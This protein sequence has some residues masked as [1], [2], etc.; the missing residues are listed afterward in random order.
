MHKPK[1]IEINIPHPCTQSWD[2][3]VPDGQGRYCAHC[4]KTVVDFTGWSDA[5]LFDF[6]AK[7]KGRSCGRFLPSQLNRQINIPHQPDSQ[8]YRLTIALGLTLLFTQTPDLLAQSKPPIASNQIA[9]QQTTVGLLGSVYDAR[10]EPTIN[11]VVQVFE[12]GVLK[13]GTV[14]DYDGNFAIKPL[15]PGNYTVVV[16]YEH[17]DS[18]VDSN[19][20]IV[21]EENTGRRYY[22]RPGDSYID[23]VK[24]VDYKHREVENY[25]PGRKLTAEDIKKTT[26][27]QVPDM[28]TMGGAYQVVDLTASTTAEVQKSQRV[29]EQPE[30]KKKHR[31]KKSKRNKM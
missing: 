3:M 21:N 20:V 4:D 12:N 7:D 18:L 2:E 6:V 24:V 16:T 13:G 1:F 31:T 15:A 25:S 9:N 26:V 5:A 30:T 23:A 19:L 29:K 11:A 14:T 28:V 27:T 10:R 17:H 22:L 8:L